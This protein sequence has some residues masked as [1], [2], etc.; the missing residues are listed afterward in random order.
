M[1]EERENHELTQLNEILSDAKKLLQSEELQKAYAIA[2]TIPL[3]LE[4]TDLAMEKAA[5]K[6]KEAQKA[7]N[8]TEGLNTEDLFNRLEKAEKAMQKAV[9][10]R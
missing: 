8:S 10:R 1:L 5:E 2:S 4:S 7:M 3:Q 9:I 6:L